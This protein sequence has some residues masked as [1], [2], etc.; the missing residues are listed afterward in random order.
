MLLGGEK[1]GAGLGQHAAGV[2]VE[3]GGRAQC[4][5]AIGRRRVEAEENHVLFFLDLNVS[6]LD[7]SQLS[8]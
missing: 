7:Q 2:C 8:H 4:C 1:Q 6:A 3:G 5:G